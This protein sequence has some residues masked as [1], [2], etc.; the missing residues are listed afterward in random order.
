[1][2]SDFGPS[3]EPGEKRA[4]LIHHGSLQFADLREEQRLRLVAAADEVVAIQMANQVKRESKRVLALEERSQKLVQKV[5]AKED[6]AAAMQ[7]AREIEEQASAH[8]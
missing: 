3:V 4:A 2:P 7:L 6:Y 8:Q 1:M 5:L